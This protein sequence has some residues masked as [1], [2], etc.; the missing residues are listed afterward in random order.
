MNP[1]PYEFSWATILAIAS[2]GAIGALGRYFVSLFSSNIGLFSNTLVVNLMGS[3]LLGM[4]TGL[5]W[6]HTGLTPL[7]RLALTTGLLGAFTTF[8]SFSIENAHL[9]QKEQWALL[10]LN[11]V[12]QV[13]GGILLA[14][15]GIYIGNRWN[16]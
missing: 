9:I 6:E 4:L 3:L 5:A 11:L 12:V 15:L 13:L 8:S 7:V 2:G 1:S 16:G 14:L 10:S